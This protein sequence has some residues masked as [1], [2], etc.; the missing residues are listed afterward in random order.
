MST[1]A[2][3]KPRGLIC[4]TCGATNKMHCFRSRKGINKIARRWE[5]KCG[6][7]ITTRELI[8]TAPV[9]KAEKMLGEALLDGAGVPR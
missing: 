7:R 5:C 8:W 1:T 2:T 4:P 3:R 9:R 6:A